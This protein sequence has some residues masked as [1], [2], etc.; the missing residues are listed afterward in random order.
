MMFSLT[1]KWKTCQAHNDERERERG[2]KT[3][4]NMVM[5]GPAFKTGPAPL[6][7]TKLCY[8]HVMKL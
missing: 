6:S 2:A 3:H 8:N 5:P 1:E 7:G 4:W